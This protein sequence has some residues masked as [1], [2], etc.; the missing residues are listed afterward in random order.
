[1]KS[2][3]REWTGFDDAHV[4]VES[5]V[6]QT[7]GVKN[8]FMRGVFIQADQK[9]LNERVYPLNE[10][11]RAVMSMNERLRRGNSIMGEM[12]HPDTLTVNLDKVSHIITD[13]RMEGSNGIGTLKLLP[14][15]PG[16]II[17]SLIE[18]GVKLGVSS[19]GSGNVDHRGFVSDF[20]I[21]TVDIVAQ[22]SAPDAY[23]TPVFESLYSTGGYKI[24]EEKAN[25]VLHNVRGAQ[26]DLDEEIHAFF[27]HLR[28]NK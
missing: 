11:S 27:K 18:N 9:N 20:E 14:T 24:M 12:D 10:I 16:L 15:P 2:M 13:I 28:N 3:I 5:I 8:C 1:M 4:V 17:R 22:P 21:V 7:T 26:R 19:R 25:R 6:D 23:P